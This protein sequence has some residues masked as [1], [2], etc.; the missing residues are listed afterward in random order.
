MQRLIAVVT[1]VA[2]SSMTTDL[3]AETA[4]IIGCEP[5]GEMTPH[6]GFK[7]PEDL[8]AL[9]GGRFLLLSEMGSM[10]D[11]SVEGELSVFDIVQGKRLPL[12]IRWNPNGENWADP[13]CAVP[14]ILNPH[15]IDLLRRPDGRLALFAVNHGG[16]EA[17]EV[18]ELIENR[19]SWTAVWRGCA[20]PP[21]DPLLNDVTALPD[22]GFATT[23][24][25]DKDSFT[26]VLGF[27]LLLGLDTG[28]VW[29]WRPDSGFTQIAGTEG[30]MP[31]GIASSAD[32]HLLYIDY[33]TENRA[34]RF[35]RTT[36]EVVGEFEISQP[37]NVVIDENGQLWIAGHH[38]FIGNPDCAG[39]E[40]ACPWKYT[41]A[42]VDPTTMEGKVVLEHEGP[43]MGFATVALP[44]GDRLFLGTA[45]GD[46]IVSM[47]RP[48]D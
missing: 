42:R 44:V 47:P 45:E 2:M 39:I 1:V 31:N 41:V 12:E 19:G 48:A 11:A 10:L 33:Y 40:G 26:P 14:Q 35:D 46:R 16:R 17:V 29:E 21:G 27:K 3:R 24:M 25:W 36:G 32:G 8:V 7:N 34:V 9:P 22:G 4:G 37:D 30:S 18:F 20:L 43:P 28:W 13:E 5:V 23:H 15:G 6:C 38:Q